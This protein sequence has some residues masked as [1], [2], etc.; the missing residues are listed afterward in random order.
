MASICRSSILCAF[1][2]DDDQYVIARP[3]SRT[4]GETGYAK[5][6]QNHPYIQVDHRDPIERKY[7]KM[8]HLLCKTALCHYFHPWVSLATDIRIGEVAIDRVIS[9]AYH[10]HACFEFRP[11]SPDQEPVIQTVLAEYRSVSR[12]VSYSLAAEKVCLMKS[13]SWLRGRRARVFLNE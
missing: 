12:R 5:I 13:L 4:Y 9:S 8:I 6:F 7:Q 11:A 3:G 1:K 2:Q 10:N